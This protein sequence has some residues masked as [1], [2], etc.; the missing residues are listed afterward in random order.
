MFIITIFTTACNSSNSNDPKVV[1][2]ATVGGSPDG[3]TVADSGNIYI[4]DIDSGTISQIDTEGNVTVIED[5][6]STV[7]IIEPDG[8]TAVTSGTTD[9]IYVA[10]AGSASDTSTTDGSIIKISVTSDGT[11]TTT[12]F[13][14]DL[15]LTNPTGIA[16]DNSGNLY[17]ADQG[18]GHIYKI[19]VTGDTAGAPVSLTNSLPASVDLLEPHGL[20]LVTNDDNSITLYTTDQDPD[21]NNIV[22]ID[23]PASG[24]IAD[25]VV[26]EL[27]ADNSG[28]TDTGTVDNAQFNKPHGISTDSNGAVFVCDENNNR[29]QIITPGGNVVTF[30]GNGASGDT[31]GDADNAQFNKPRGLAVDANG[32]LLVCDYGNG[33][34]K[35]IIR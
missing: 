8:I 21:S 7:T 11:V 6:T 3:V 20:T 33:K 4:T 15:T 18:T 31:D 30:A 12:E 35:K 34:V 22:Q 27:T 29:V 14:N 2:V 28:G 19:P 5:T 9:I 32:D 13:L 24:I 16:S 25:V 23:I 26:T 17:V 1:T 10:D